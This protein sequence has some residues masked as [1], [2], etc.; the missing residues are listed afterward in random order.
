[1][2]LSNA[3]TSAHPQSGGLRPRERRGASCIPMAAP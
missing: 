2:E 1:M 3:Q